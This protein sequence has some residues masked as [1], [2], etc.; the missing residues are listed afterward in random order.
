MKCPCL[1]TEVFVQ[2]LFGIAL[3]SSP[4]YRAAA[5]T[6]APAAPAAP[7]ATQTTITTQ[8]ATTP[9]TT[10]SAAVGAPSDDA[11]T[12]QL[13]LSPTK[14]LENFEPDA[15]AEYE[16]GP[17]DEIT[18][19][20]PGHPELS[21]KHIVGPDGRITLPVAGT[22]EVADKTRLGASQT[23]KDALTPYY[24][25]LSITLG[26]DK[27]GS[28]HV[29]VLGN[30]KNPGV[31]SFDGTPTLLEAITR[32]G[33]SASPTTKDGIPDTC[34]IYRKNDQAMQVDL[35][36]LLTSGNGLAADMRLRRGDFI[37][38]PSQ[39]D[40]FV[41]VMGE[42]N[43]PG[44]VPLT[45]ELSLHLAI[46]NAGGL[47]DLASKNISV[48]QGSTGKTITITYKQMMSPNGD[49]EIVLHAGDIIAIP[50]SG[51]GK[52]TALLQRISPIATMITIGA[53]LF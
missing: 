20:V 16:L 13:K 21:T 51:M 50:R 26:V 49:R 8:A 25:D 45:P 31:I 29:T 44:A 41:S 12:P 35:R 23:I 19:D 18:L 53:V 34:M 48:I 38:I 27:Y 2:L 1:K 9:A 4:A 10:A 37:F 17:G 22:V 36:A 47:T 7:T 30:V 11:D 43:H 14:A 5:Q 24:T 15:N 28:N 3:A 32:A 33:L 46:A 40:Q 39:K 42:V 6:L 52:A